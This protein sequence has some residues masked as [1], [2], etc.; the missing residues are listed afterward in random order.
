MHIEGPGDIARPLVRSRTVLA[1]A[2]EVAGAAQRQIGL[3]EF[4]AVGLA[5]EERESEFERTE[6][7]HRKSHRPP[8][9]IGAH[10]HPVPFDH[11]GDA[12]DEATGIVETIGQGLQVGRQ[13][14]HRHA[15]FGGELVESLRVPL[16]EARQEGHQPSEPRGCGAHAAVPFLS[17]ERNVAL[18]APVAGTAP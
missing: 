1:H 14:R 6:L 15:A 9:V 17:G 11:H 5:L 18:S 12:L 3:G 2:A 7:G 13:L 16:G 10:R 4:Q 8:E